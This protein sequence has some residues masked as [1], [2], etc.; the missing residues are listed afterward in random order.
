MNLLGHPIQCTIAEQSKRLFEIS[1]VCSSISL[2]YTLLIILLHTAR[3]RTQ[4]QAD[5]DIGQHS[6]YLILYFCDLHYI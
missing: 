2:M 3:K 1:D 5:D 4:T 6:M